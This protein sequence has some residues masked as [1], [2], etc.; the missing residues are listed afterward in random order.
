MLMLINLSSLYQGDIKMV[1]AEVKI[2]QRFF[3]PYSGEFY[4]KI[5]E[6]MADGLG[7]DGYFDADDE[8]ELDEGGY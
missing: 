1:F 5:N 4:V 3:D 7:E 2:G 8:V 6:N